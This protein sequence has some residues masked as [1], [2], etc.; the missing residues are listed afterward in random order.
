MKK[1]QEIWIEIE[2][3]RTIYRKTRRFAF[4]DECQTQAEFLTFAEAAALVETN[5][6][7]IFALADAGTLHSTVAE[8]GILLVCLCSLL[9]T[10]FV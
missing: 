8:N 4:C 2:R 6:E 3:E 5:T 7:K 9:G 10:S 1:Q